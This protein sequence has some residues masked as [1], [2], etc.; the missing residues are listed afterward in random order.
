MPTTA[1]I[2]R[3]AQSQAG[4]ERDIATL[5]IAA[6]TKRVAEIDAPVV[7][8]LPTPGPI[9]TKQVPDNGNAYEIRKAGTSIG[10]V[11]ML[12]G[13]GSAFYIAADNVHVS[14]DIG[15]VGQYPIEIEQGK[16]IVLS[17]TIN[18]GS[19]YQSHIRVLTPNTDVKLDH[20]VLNDT[21]AQDKA[22][23]RG[24]GKWTIVG[25]SYSGAVI[26]CAN[27]LNRGDGGR[28]QL[29]TTIL[30]G[31]KLAD[32]W[33]YHCKNADETRAAVMRA[34]KTTS[35]PMALARVFRDTAILWTDLAQT[36]TAACKDH[37][38]DA[39]L[40][41]N[42]KQRAAAL[43]Q[44][45]TADWTQGAQIKNAIALEPN[46]VSTFDGTVKVNVKGAFFAGVL[47]QYPEADWALPY[48]VLRKPPTLTMKG[49]EIFAPGGWG[50]SA[51]VLKMV[52]R[53]WC[54]FN[55]AMVQ[56]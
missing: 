44:G 31:V 22:L 53:G 14:A 20:C 15:S 35:D 28:E 7:V 43:A 17:V 55:G 19:K 4:T 24:P 10:P 1:E 11:K 38:P 3:A 45:G 48:D 39:Q 23:L 47:L 49:D 2:L 9:A 46:N 25:G 54:K 26:G 5:T 27:A 41:I 50:V 37:C 40:L 16:G 36:K 51:D 32:T 34:A 33:I 56:F 13:K 21:F 42:I 30:L 52:M 29:V 12:D 6:L 18:G 8:P